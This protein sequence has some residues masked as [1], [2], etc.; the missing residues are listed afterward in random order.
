MSGAEPDTTRQPLD[1]ARCRQVVE[2]THA[3]IARAAELGGRRM[4]SVSIRFDLRG[5]SFGQY[6]RT[7]RGREIRFNPWAFAADFDHHLAQT[8][9]HEVAHLAVDVMYRRR[10]RPHGAEWRA[11]MQAFGVAATV[12][13]DRP[14]GDTPLRRQSRYAYGCSCR[15][16][17]LSATRHN[18]ARRGAVYYC[19]QCRQPLVALAGDGDRPA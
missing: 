15:R 1:P 16:H 11:M 17:L 6:R 7:A 14:L 3:W 4:P 18:R 12:T 9:P 5:R 8:V 19:R 10:V 13:C 2:A